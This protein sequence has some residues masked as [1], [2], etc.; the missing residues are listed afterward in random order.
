[1]KYLKNLLFATAIAVSAVLP[2][3]L[4]AQTPTWYDAF[5]PRN[6]VVDGFNSYG[7]PDL[8]NNKNLKDDLNLIL[9]GSDPKADVD[10]DDHPGTAQDVQV[11]TEYVNGDRDY[12]PGEYWR[13]TPSEKEGWIRKV[14]PISVRLSNYEFISPLDPRSQDQNTR[15]DSDN[16]S[17]ADFLNL[18][19]YNPNRVDFN[20]I[21]PKYSL[22]YNGLFNLPAYIARVHSDDGNFNHG[23]IAF[24]TGTNLNDPNGWIF[25][26]AQEGR[27][28]EPG[29]DWSIPFSS[30]VDILGV[31]DFESSYNSGVIDLPKTTV[32]VY[33]HFDSQG[34]REITYMNPVMIE[35]QTTLDI[36]DNEK[37]NVSNKFLLKQNF[38]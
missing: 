8:N 12:L 10:G 17:L 22:T 2:G 5:N 6:E 32:A 11:Y 20:L 31:H 23:I 14:Y 3:K 38:P 34:N 18:N 1:M 9:G 35:D 4:N 28:I 13:S 21:H 19:G 33:I 30:R 24:F 15:F 37:T 36:K 7:I 16:G 29:V 25:G 27:I 26:D